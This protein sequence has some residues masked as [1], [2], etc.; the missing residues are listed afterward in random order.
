[1]IA[2]IHQ[3]SSSTFQL[4][5]K[6]M[7]LSGGRNYYFGSVDGINSHFDN[8]GLPIPTHTNP[9]EF[10]IELLNTDFAS[11]NVDAQ[12]C[13]Q[14]IE[15]GWMTSP[16]PQNIKDRIQQVTTT[17]EP[18]PVIKSPK[19]NFPIVLMTLV[20]RSF[21]KSHRDVVAYGVRIAMYIGLAIMMGTVWL[22]LPT[23]QSSI[24]PLSNAIVS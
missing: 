5:D 11:N 3:P 4:F 20:H 2:S 23:S 15:Q 10:V 7:L 9:A 21:I 18:L 19:R 6:L 22:R 24:Q 17:K 16:R 13:L 8:L 14:T 1:M 12:E